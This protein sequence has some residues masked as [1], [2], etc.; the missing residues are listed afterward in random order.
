MLT[1]VVA[2]FL[3][4]IAVLAMFGRLRVGPPR[5]GRRRPPERLSR[6][7]LCTSCNRLLVGSEPCSCGGSRGQDSGRDP[8]QG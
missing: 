8:P 6:A 1:K 7:R 5:I 2:L 3:V 4:A